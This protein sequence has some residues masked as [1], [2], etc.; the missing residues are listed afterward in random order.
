M[1]IRHPLPLLTREVPRIELNPTH[2]I[3]LVQDMHAP[4]ADAAHG[5]LAQRAREKVVRREFDEYF[6][7][8]DR[9]AA[10]VP[11][12]LDSARRVG[13][14]I[15]YSCTGYA[16][17]AEPSAWQRALGWDW[18]LTGADGAFPIEWRPQPGERIWAKPGWSA[19]SNPGLAA[20]LDAR[21]IRNVLLIGAMFEFGL[22]QTALNLA[23]S[24]RG[25]LIVSDG[26]VALTEAG[27]RQA[28]GEIAHGLTKLRTTGE[29]LDLLV[30]LADESVVPV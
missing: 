6:D 23:D 19:L 8:L 24:G 29:T 20:W 9:V 7:A 1:S 14:P 21:A 10:N 27:R 26:A 22:R 25:C 5:W 17:P 18:D 4:F 30:R 15:L 28:S 16:P 11:R 2:T 3:L 12:L 13:L